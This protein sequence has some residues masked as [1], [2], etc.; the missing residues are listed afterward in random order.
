MTFNE[1]WTLLLERNPKW[2]DP[3]YVI[4][5]NPLLFKRAMEQAYMQG[6]KRSDDGMSMEDLL[7]KF[8]GK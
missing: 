2:R 3:D 7:G 8:G 4:K 1:L 6:K 5:T